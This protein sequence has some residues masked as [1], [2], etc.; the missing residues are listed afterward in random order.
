[1]LHLVSPPVTG[2]RHRAPLPIICG[3]LM[4]QMMS[5]IPALA[6]Q[7]H[8]HTMPATSADRKQHCNARRTITSK[9][10]V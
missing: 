8:P 7:G 10:P 6:S 5:M 1:M 3:P 4:S 9:P 2:M